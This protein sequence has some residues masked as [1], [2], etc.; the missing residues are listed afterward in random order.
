M[1]AAARL[2]CVLSFVGAPAAQCVMT[3]NALAAG[4]DGSVRAIVR[5]P[6]GSYVVGGAFHL[7]GGTAAAC[8]AR[9]DGAAWAPLGSGMS[10]SPFP[11]GPIVHSLLVLPNGDLVA[12]GI[13]DTAGGVAAANIAH[14]HGSAW[15]PLG[16]GS[17]GWIRA[18]CLL[19]NGDLVAAGGFVLGGTNPQHIARWDG[20]AWS[21]L[22]TGLASYEILALAVLP[23][24]DL[25]AGGTFVAAAGPSYLARWDGSTWSQLG[26]IAGGFFG[27]GVH[28][29][30][31]LPNGDLVVGGNFTSAGG[32][33]AN[34]VA[35]WDGSAW[36][37]FGSGVAS[38]TFTTRVRALTLLA[39]GD[40]VAGGSFETAGG[41]PANHLARWNGAAWSPLGAGADSGLHAALGTNG[42]ELLAAGD[43]TQV[44][45]VPANRVALRTTGC[46]ATSSSYGNGCLGGGGATALV[47]TRLA[48]LGGAVGAHASGA[49]P[50]ALA[51]GVYGFASLA[52]PMPLVHG[53]GIPGCTLLVHDDILLQF[54]V[55]G[56][57]V[58]T[59]LTIPNAPGLV[60]G[61]FHHQVV[62]IEVTAGGD[63][64]ALSSTDA[65]T[66][67]IG[68]L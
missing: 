60:G 33:A 3:W 11:G 26:P 19:P 12:G 62:F 61:V 59:A 4:V 15:S 8:V 10:G 31:A 53:L 66:F 29:L 46:A 16:T 37:P 57:T 65:L 55:V 47:P 39:N 14:W 1:R 22:G 20:V 2:F 43:F 40:L 23:N 45:G 54:P 9:W 5:M 64:A 63:L 50:N 30:L 48:W 13:F 44:D 58:A 41:L 24:G 32:V 28:T 34:F 36:H 18:L 68:T 35:R 38:S 56:T 67:T 52:L 7:A 17:P 42:G 51:V 27:T 6:D 49:A 21:P 25:V